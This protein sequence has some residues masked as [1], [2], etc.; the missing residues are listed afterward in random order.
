MLTVMH[1]GFEH[2]SNDGAKGLIK[3]GIPTSLVV[4]ALRLK[5]EKDIDSAAGHARA[6]FVS[7]GSYIDHEYLLAKQEAQA[8]LDNGKDESAVPSS[9]EDHMAMFDVGPEAAARAIIETAAQ[10]E[11]ALT[12]IR[13]VRLGGKSDVRNAE[14]VEAAEAAAQ[15]AIAALSDIRPPEGA[16]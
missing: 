6:A 2:T 11:Q 10:W 8:W 13:R 9:V 15:D 1:N 7:P 3:M 12:L 5:L 16:L 4:G 14:T